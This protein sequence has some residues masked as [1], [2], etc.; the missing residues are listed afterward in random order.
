MDVLDEMT[1]FIMKYVDNAM[2]RLDASSCSDRSDRSVLEKLL[3][4]NRE[5]AIVMVYDMIMAGV[6]TVRISIGFELN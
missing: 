3:K 6:D 4:I 2:Q 1:K 5:L